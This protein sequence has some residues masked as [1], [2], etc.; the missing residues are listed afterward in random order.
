MKC[1]N[2]ISLQN[3]HLI[4]L[5]YWHIHSNIIG[6]YRSLALSSYASSM[7]EPGRV[8]VTHTECQ[9]EVGGL[10]CESRGHWILPPRT[11]N[12]YPHRDGGRGSTFE[13]RARAIMAS[14]CNKTTSPYSP[15]SSCFPFSSLFPH[16]TPIPTT[17]LFPR[18]S[19]TVGGDNVVRIVLTN[20]N[21][22]PPHSREQGNHL[23]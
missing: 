17:S 14:M 13:Q 11:K 4:D 9:R 16:P 5:Q 19:G 2:S 20:A 15:N 10:S 6:I 22:T 3:L 1:A 23:L 18:S 12:C 7:W 8:S 21:L